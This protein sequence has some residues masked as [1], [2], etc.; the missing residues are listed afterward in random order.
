VLAIAKV[1]TAIAVVELAVVIFVGAIP[2]LVGLPDAVL[3][4]SGFSNM[5]GYVVFGLA[6]LAW[7]ALAGFACLRVNSA[8]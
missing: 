5:L 1:V 7:A 8:S 2:F 3:R 6:G 4:N